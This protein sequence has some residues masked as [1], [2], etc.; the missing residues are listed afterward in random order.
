MLDFCVAFVDVI[1]CGFNECEVFLLRIELIIIFSFGNVRMIWNV[2]CMIV[3]IYCQ[4]SGFLWNC[5]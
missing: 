3:E 5:D 2:L 1:G 4:L